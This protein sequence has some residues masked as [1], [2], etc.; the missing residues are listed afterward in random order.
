MKNKVNLY[1]ESASDFSIT[2]EEGKQRKTITPYE[3]EVLWRA[4][5]VYDFN[6]AFA[7]LIH[8]DFDLAQVREFYKGKS[9]H[10]RSESA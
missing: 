9:K 8:S 5:K 6:A 7:R 4:G 2:M 10:C 3:A 1:L